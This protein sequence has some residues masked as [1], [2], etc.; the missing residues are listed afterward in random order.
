MTVVC[1]LLHLRSTSV[2]RSATVWGQWTE[3]RAVSVGVGQK[4]RKIWSFLRHL[5]LK[6]LPFD[7][8]SGSGIG[9]NKK[10]HYIHQFLWG[11]HNLGSKQV[12]WNKDRDC[13]KTDRYSRWR[14]IGTHKATRAQKEFPALRKRPEQSDNDGPVWH[15]RGEWSASPLCGC[16]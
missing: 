13:Y 12:T 15:G 10:K 16:S 6:R 1:H 14:H 11:N 4:E 5:F 7:S 8:P 2:K 9:K 3:L